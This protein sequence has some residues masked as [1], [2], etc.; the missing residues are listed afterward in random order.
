MH[1]AYL[2]AGVWRE[3]FTKRSGPKRFSRPGARRWTGFEAQWE[4]QGKFGNS[5]GCCCEVGVWRLCIEGRGKIE[6]YW[7]MHSSVAVIFIRSCI[8]C[9]ST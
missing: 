2:E 5:C 3:Q 7:L 9:V 6:G 8:I 1:L 4:S